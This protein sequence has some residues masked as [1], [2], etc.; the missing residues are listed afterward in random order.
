MCRVEKKNR[1]DTLFYHPFHLA[2]VSS[3]SS[4]FCLPPR[5]LIALFNKSCNQ[6]YHSLVT[7]HTTQPW[8]RWATTFH[9]FFRFEA[10]QFS[11]NATIIHSQQKEGKRWIYKI[12]QSSSAAFFFLHS[13]SSNWSSTVNW[14]LQNNQFVLPIKK[15][16]LNWVFNCF[17]LNFIYTFCIYNQHSREEGPAL[18]S[19]YHSAPVS[20][21]LALSF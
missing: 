19:L 6:S 10:K 5:L 2:P 1:R 7:C 9:L 12:C 20:V 8:N 18:I 11:L 4:G 21:L 16:R 15:F 3:L 17:T 13:L 14:K